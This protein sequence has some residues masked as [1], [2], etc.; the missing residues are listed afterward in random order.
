M[1]NLK[2]LGLGMKI[3]VDDNSDIFPGCASRHYGYQPEDWIY[4]R[5]NTAL[6]PPFKQSPILSSFSGAQRPSFLCP[7][8]NNFNDRLALVYPNPPW[9]PDGYGPYLFSYSLTGYGLDTNNEN[10]GMSSVVDTSGGTP[11]IYTFKE[12]SVCNPGNKIMLAEQPGSLE[13]NDSPDKNIPDQAK[14]VTCGRWT[15]VGSP[16]T[17]PA[18]P[19]TVRHSGK[20]DVTFADGHVAPV[21]SDFGSDAKN[22]LPSF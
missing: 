7:L 15:P 5:T 3:Y 1:N 14:I 21:T 13:H 10:L 22:S 16:V 8:D 17:G 12:S 6:Y 18:E 11:V 20:A 19:L 9:P 2:Q 4:W